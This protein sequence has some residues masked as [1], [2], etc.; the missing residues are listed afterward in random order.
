[1]GGLS[2]ASLERM[3]LAGTVVLPPD[4]VMDE[5][6]TVRYQK[7]LTHTPRDQPSLAVSCNNKNEESSS[8][9]RHYHY[10]YHEHYHH[11]HHHHRH[12]HITT[13]TT[14]RA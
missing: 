10:N 5:S 12:H 7:L 4:V 11:H 6:V 3:C 8:V 1:M 9:N 2:R 14:S 13:I